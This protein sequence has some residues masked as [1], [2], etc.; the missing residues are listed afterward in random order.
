MRILMICPQFRPLVGGYERAAERLSA[1]L[2]RRGHEVTV[3]TE[4][5]DP[6]WPARESSAGY[7]LRRLWVWYRRGW[8]G[9]TSLLTHVFWLLKHGRGFDVWH[10]HQ[11]GAHASLAILT[12]KLLRRPVALKLTSSGAQGVAAA[13]QGLRAHRLHGWAHRHVAACLAVSQETAEEAMKFGIPSERIHRVGNG[14]DLANWPATTGDAQAAARTRLGLGEGFLAVAVGRLAEEKNPLGLVDAWAKARRSL[15]DSARLAWVGDGPL[16]SVMEAHIRA[17]Q[18]ERAVIVAGHSNAVADWLNAADAYVL[19]SRNEGMANTL[20]EA[21]ASGLPS[22]A[23]AVSGTNELIQATGAG[24]VVPVGDMEALAGAIM[25]LVQDPAMRASMG[26]RARQIIEQDYSLGVV[27]DKIIAIYK[28]I[29]PTS[30][31]P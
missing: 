27:A 8:H 2:S 21:M 6:S 9:T 3:L 28:K 16:R 17:L 18:L 7:E 26:A 4:L 15:P 24:L 25:Q 19:S 13:I 12:G 14:L 23:T 11:Y 31:S 10:V 20:L 22:V 1:E 29:P 30:I 5:R